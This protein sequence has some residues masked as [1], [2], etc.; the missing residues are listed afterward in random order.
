MFKLA[1]LH[2][3]PTVYGRSMFKTR[4]VAVCAFSKE[5]FS[6]GLEWLILIVLPHSLSMLNINIEN[7]I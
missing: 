5:D 4:Y 1:E 6:P 3:G 7:I 2:C